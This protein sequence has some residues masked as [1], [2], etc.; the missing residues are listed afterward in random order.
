MKKRI[1][2][3]NEVLKSIKAGLPGLYKQHVKGRTVQFIEEHRPT[4][5]DDCLNGRKVGR[6][7]KDLKLLWALGELF[8]RQYSDFVA[9]SHREVKKEEIQDPQ[10]VYVEMQYMAIF[11]L[12]ILCNALFWS[13]IFARFCAL[14][15]SSFISTQTD[16]SIL[17]VAD[18]DMPKDWTEEQKPERTAGKLLT[19]IVLQIDIINFAAYANRVVEEKR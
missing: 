15:K 18:E 9:S 12:H 14:P 7:R 4:R 1:R 10:K 6:V 17:N 8:R 3:G 19:L 5:S 11:S 2:Y 13:E 16:W